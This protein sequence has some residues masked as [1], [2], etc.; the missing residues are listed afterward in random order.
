MMMPVALDSEQADGVST[1]MHAKP[2]VCGEIAKEIIQKCW[3]LTI[4]WV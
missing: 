2:S 1:F 4:G 3:Y